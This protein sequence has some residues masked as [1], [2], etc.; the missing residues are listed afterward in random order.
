MPYLWMVQNGQGTRAEL[1]CDIETLWAN[2]TDLACCCSMLA[3]GAAARGDALAPLCQEHLMVRKDGFRRNPNPNQSCS[4]YENEECGRKHE[5]CNHL[6]ARDGCGNVS[7][8]RSKSPC[9]HV[10]QMARTLEPSALSVCTSVF[11]I[12]QV[13]IVCDKVS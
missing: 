2:C 13:Q 12:E 3:A 11:E 10:P 7:M 8:C 1:C 5:V 4:G 6:S 9:P